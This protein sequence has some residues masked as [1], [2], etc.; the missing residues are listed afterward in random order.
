MVAWEA[1]TRIGDTSKL[2]ALRGEV[3]VVR[4]REKDW[5]APWMSGRLFTH[6]LHIN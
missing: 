3:L 4:V 6:Y 1:R 5:G 2:L